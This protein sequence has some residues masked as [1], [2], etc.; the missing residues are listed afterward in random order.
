MQKKGVDMKIV[1]VLNGHGPIYGVERHVLTLAAAQKERGHSIMAI[2]NI[3]AEF[4]QACRANGIQI[5]VNPRLEP[6][7]DH[8]LYLDDQIM[9]NAIKSLSSQLAG[10]RADL[11]HCHNPLS[12]SLAMP[13]ANKAHIPCFFTLHIE[14]KPEFFSQ[15][16]HLR[17]AVIAVSTLIF[18]KAQAVVSPGTDLFLIPNGTPTMPPEILNTRGAYRP[19]LMM[20]GTLHPLKGIDAAILAMFLLHLKL[21]RDCPTL[22]IYGSGQSLWIDYF[23]EM[24]EALGIADVVSFHGSR[25]GILRD[26]PAG[27]ILVVASRNE[28]GPLVVLEAMSRGMPVVTS[29]VGEV[30]DMLPDAR[31][32]RIVPVNS[33]TG[34]AD[35]IESTLRDVNS[36]RFEPELIIARHRSFFSDI[37]MA[38]RVEEIYARVMSKQTVA[39]PGGHLQPGAADQPFRMDRRV[40]RMT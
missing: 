16:K 17:F 6:M 20:V 24:A 28:S 8:G 35:A 19:D 3:D 27:D 37:V 32:G 2:S 21:G 18:N 30:T 9:E 26:C 33:I 5:T 10:F 31:Y 13:A 23:K 7:N 38:Q 12:A 11:I 40:G 36:G 15:T 1:H 39:R 34:L 14:P 4:A 29:H 25:P 22:N